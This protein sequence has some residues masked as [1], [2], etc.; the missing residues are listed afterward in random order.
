V[1]NASRHRS[2]FFV[3]GQS[4]SLTCLPDTEPIHSRFWKIQ[5]R[6]GQSGS[7]GNQTTHIPVYSPSVHHCDEIDDLF[8]K[9]RRFHN[10]VSLRHP[11][12]R[13]ETHARNG[14]K[15]RSTALRICRARRGFLPKGQTAP[16]S[17]YDRQSR[18]LLDVCVRSP[19]EWASAS[20][21]TKSKRGKDD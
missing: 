9:I 16:F 21:G 19:A 1:D 7:S 10:P 3:G 2:G 14:R 5:D 15:D 11:Y 17:P 12:T 8:P 13:Y 6:F 20:S 4:R 18:H